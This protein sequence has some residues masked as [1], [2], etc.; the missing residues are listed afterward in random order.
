MS[1][2]TQSEVANFLF[3]DF[4]KKL[5]HCTVDDTWYS[6]D[7]TKPISLIR[8]YEMIIEQINSNADLFS[9]GYSWSDVVGVCDLLRI[10]LYAGPDECN[11]IGNDGYQS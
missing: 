4:S 10:S 1:R 7:D 6:V 3:A 2:N 5:R 8:V 11:E 9:N